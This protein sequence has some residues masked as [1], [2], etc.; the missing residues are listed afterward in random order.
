VGYNKLKLIAAE[1]AKIEEPNRHINLSFGK[2]IF[3]IA[4]EQ[5][6]EGKY[7]KPAQELVRNLLTDK[8]NLMIKNRP[9]N[10]K[11]ESEITKMNYISLQ[12]DMLT[13]SHLI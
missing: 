13:A 3:P 7:G 9:I 8:I 4:P 12:K 2:Q 10:S 1:L 6:M 11:L 5:L